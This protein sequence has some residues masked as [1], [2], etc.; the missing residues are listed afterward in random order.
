M[1]PRQQGKEVRKSLT[2]VAHLR[3]E[4]PKDRSQLWPQFQQPTGKEVGQGMLH[5]PQLV[6]MR[7]EARS[8]DAEDKVLRRC[9]SPQ[10]KAGR[11]LQRIERA[12]DLHAGKRLGRKLQLPALGKLRRVEHATPAGIAPAR[13][14]NPHRPTN[15]H[16]H[17]FR[18]LE[19]PVRTRKPTPSTLSL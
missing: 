13:D 6:P 14:P 4:L 8:L 5:V 15:R 3:R 12:I 19:A 17:L 1:S 7:D 16:T 10:P 2:R 11:P 18:A 9:S